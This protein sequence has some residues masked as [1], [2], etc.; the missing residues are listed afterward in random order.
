M[1]S[2]MEW[3]DH[4]S[5]SRFVAFSDL[6][7][8]RYALS[9]IKQPNPR[10]YNVEV[11]FI[12]LDSENLGELVDD[13]YH[14]DFGDNQFPYYKGNSNNKTILKKYE[15]DSGTDSDEDSRNQE[16]KDNKVDISTYVPPCV[17]QYLNESF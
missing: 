8:S 6:Q 11:A 13:R 4:P 14:T 3:S 15:E 9:Y 1:A 16:N 2:W 10:A 7:P 17:I 12:A 5:M